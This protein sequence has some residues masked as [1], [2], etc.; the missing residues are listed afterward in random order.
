[1]IGH[2]RPKPIL[3]LRILGINTYKEAVIFMREDCHVCRSEGFEVQARV[4]VTLKG[5]NLIATLNIVTSEIL[6]HGEASLSDFALQKLAAKDGDE[7]HVSHPP[8]VHSLSHMR[9]KIYGN[10][11]EADHLQSI[12]DDIVAGRY[13]DIHVSAFLTACAGG[14]LNETEIVHLTR[15]MVDSGDRLDWGKD[16]VVDK[17]CIG[18][19]P[20]NRTTPIVVAI[21]AAYGLTMPKTSSRAITSLAGTA[22]TME[23]LTN[24]NLDAAAMRKVVEK[25]NGC[26]VWGGSVT[27]SPADDLLIRVEK[28]LDIDSEGQ[29]I[30]SVLSKKIAAGSSH[31][32]IDMPIGPTAKIRS[33]K[34]AGKL[35]RYLEQT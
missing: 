1:M 20:G 35:T 17:H 31:V 8:Q 21:I 33:I 9:S 15:A 23:V 27:L 22:D 11:L 6:Q 30:A 24:V 28:A 5:V 10:V 19:L 16:L 4:N 7:I 13:S 29:L 32:L 2:E 34:M 12:V 18:G 3:K 26:V 14:R 25:E